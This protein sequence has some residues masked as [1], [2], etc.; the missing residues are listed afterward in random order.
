[1]PILPLAAFHAPSSV[2]TYVL[3]FMLSPYV[4]LYCFVFNCLYFYMQV[5]EWYIIVNVVICLQLIFGW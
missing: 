3:S 5:F 1:M 2:I 4:E